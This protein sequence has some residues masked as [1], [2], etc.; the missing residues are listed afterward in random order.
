MTE[1]A[2]RGKVK[3]PDTG[4]ASR[5]EK[6]SVKRGSSQLFALAP[7]VSAP[8]LLD[9]TG[10]GDR[11]FRQLL[12][13]ISIAAAHLESARSYLAGHMDVTPPQYNMVMIIAQYEGQSGISVSEIASHLHVSNTF[14]TSE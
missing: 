10:G 8:A 1:S 11:D 13:D 9:A 7:T 5:P 6:A 14:V 4:R 2:G 12:Y 3:A